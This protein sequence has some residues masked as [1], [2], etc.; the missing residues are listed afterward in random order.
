MK[1]HVGL[2]RFDFRLT[3]LDAYQPWDVTRAVS[4]FELTDGEHVVRLDEQEIF[5]SEDLSSESAR[6]RHWL[7]YPLVRTWEDLLDLL[8]YAKRPVPA[9][10]A[11]R[12][13]PEAGWKRWCERARAWMERADE[14]TFEELEQ[15]FDWASRRTLDVG[16]LVAAPRLTF[17]NVDGVVHATCEPLADTSSVGWRWICE[18]ASV[19]LPVAEFIR[20]VERFANT[21]LADMEE[22]LAAIADGA[23][24]GRAVVDSVALQAQHT[25]REEQLARLLAAVADEDEDWDRIARALEMLDRATA[26][27]GP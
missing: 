14:T 6:E 13:E 16:H 8:P 19:E 21:L 2:L 11:R 5:S 9:G 12:I 27:T 25:A 23:L 18:P 1:A 22:R 7:D 10:I 4:W 17:A 24:S 20:E 15:A 3:P 26:W